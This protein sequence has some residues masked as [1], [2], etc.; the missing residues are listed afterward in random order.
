MERVRAVLPLVQNWILLNTDTRVRGYRS[1][2][3]M[4][5][6]GHIGMFVSRYGSR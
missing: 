2:V 4:H 5:E 6:L 3:P 1:N